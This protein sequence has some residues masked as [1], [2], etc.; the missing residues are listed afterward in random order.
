MATS[1]VD[2]TGDGNATKA[3]SFPSLAE[4]DVKVEVDGV[5]K[6]ATTHYN[7]TSYNSTSGGNVVF[8]AGNIPTSSNDIRIYRDTDVS[9][10]T[11]DYDPQ[12]TF[13]AGASVKADDLNNN[14]K[15]VLY[16]I[17]EEKEQTI[18]AQDLKDNSITSSK[19][20]GN[21]INSAHLAD[22]SVGSSELQSDSVGTT[23]IK[24]N[25]VTSAKIAGDAVG[26]AQIANNA[27]TSAK[28]AG[29]AVGSAQIADGAVGS[30][31]IAAN[32]VGSAQI[33]ESAVGKSEIAAKAVG[34]PEP[35]PTSNSPLPSRSLFMTAPAASTLVAS[36]T[37]ALASIPFNLVWSASVNTLESEAASTAALI[38]ASVWSAVAF[39]ST[40][41]SFVLS[42]ELIE[43]AALVVA[44]E[45]PIA[46][47]VPPLEVIGDVPLTS[48]TVP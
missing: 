5:V 2:Y 39:V 3:F 23:Q 37:S 7:I 22:N 19:I 47:V 12:A 6:T 27:V 40:P 34:S 13:T 44:A 48:V 28:I 11:G 32:A 42:A 29:N 45:I 33:A 21:A 15:Q 4:T 38:S 16:A 20:V 24:D 14:Q 9:T 25:A 10:N 36:V 41:S 46:G 1:Y 17:W 43:P 26:S 31:E 8:T 35:S 30:S 18:T